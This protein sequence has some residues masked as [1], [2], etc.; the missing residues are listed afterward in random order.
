[1]DTLKTKL[2][3]KI[4]LYN[5]ISFQYFIHPT[6]VKSAARYRILI[7]KMCLWIYWCGMADTSHE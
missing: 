5:L 2:Q 3:N 4:L 7:D 1:M 6:G